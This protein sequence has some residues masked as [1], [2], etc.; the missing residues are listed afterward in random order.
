MASTADHDGQSLKAALKN[1]EAALERHIEEVNNLNVF[2][3]PDGDTGINMYLTLQSANAAAEGLESVSAAEVSAKVAR[4]ALLGARGNSG[5]ILSQILRGLA[6]GLEGQARFSAADFG[7]ALGEAS[8][9]AYH[10]L[11]QPVEGTIL[12]VIRETA[13]A[14]MERA[15][16]GG[17]LKRTLAAALARAKSSV[18]RTP[19]LL[20]KLREAGVVDA[21]GKGLYYFIEGLKNYYA[22]RGEQTEVKATSRLQAELAAIQASYG[23]DLQFLLEG[24]GL[25]LDAI[26]RQI[27]QMGESV[28]VVGDEKLLRVHVH[29]QQ[30]ENVKNFCR[31]FG[32]LKDI[33]QENMDRQVQEFEQSRA[34]A[35]EGSGEA[36]R[37]KVRANRP[38]RSK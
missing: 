15:A 12:T 19:D 5:V 6:R 27:C 32:E 16:G 38:T 3:V 30:P 13:E 33:V 25:P 1:S 31:S 24:E 14:A 4:G 2:P 23:Y 22:R 7:R 36:Q 18:E 35:E 29:T 8:Q 17:D 26:R 37:T 20:P 28:L 11:A 21:G 34:K 9:C 10:A